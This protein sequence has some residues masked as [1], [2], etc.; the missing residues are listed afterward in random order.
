MALI[1]CTICVT[2]CNCPGPYEP[3][4]EEDGGTDVGPP[5]APS[6]G[7]GAA[8]DVRSDGDAGEAQWI[9]LTGAPPTCDVEIAADARAA[10]PVLEFETCPDRAGCRQLVLAWPADS[11]GRRFA[12]D[13]TSGYADDA[14]GYF[15]F[16]R[17]DPANAAAGF[18]W[19]VVADDAGA[20]RAIIRHRGADDPECALGH[21]AIGEGRVAVE[22]LMGDLSSWI[23]GGD[24]DDL[25][26]TLRAVAHVD[27][28]VMGAAYVTSV[29]VGTD[30][31]AVQ[32]SSYELFRI[33]WDGEVRRVDRGGRGVDANHPSVVGSA[34]VFD[35]VDVGNHV[36]IADAGSEPVDLVPSPEAGA[37][38]SVHNRT[39][40]RSLAWLTGI[41][42]VGG[43][44]TEFER[45]ELWAS[46]FASD[47]ASMRPIRLAMM[48]SGGIHGYV[49]GG[50]GHAAV[51][52]GDFTV[53][54]LFRIADKR[55]ATLR[56]PPGLIWSGFV[57]YVGSREALIAAG[58]DDRT[59]RGRHQTAVQFI[60][61]A[62]LDL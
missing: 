39:D 31:I 40:G 13:E 25:G 29:R 57:A 53:I 16:G 41:N 55:E 27:A 47:A 15:A 56:A 34:V 48:S 49:Y 20:L 35:N 62:A 7:D 2:Q 38:P 59:G 46:P 45:A 17:P 52:D 10:A 58:P 54:R 50:F 42:R 9:A 43:S 60:A 5:D 14:R 11:A 12:I 26:G 28:T 37:E 32:T 18:R 23:L 51:I 44:P 4:F 33:R 22:L 19:L 21:V 1:V 24:L 30:V 8:A 6:P 61:V 36:L 3:P